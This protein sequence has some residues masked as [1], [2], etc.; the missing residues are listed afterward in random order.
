ML[1]TIDPFYPVDFFNE[2]KE[3]LKNNK[4]DFTTSISI[5]APYN[6][7]FDID[8]APIM[9]N[10]ESISKSNTR[11][12][13]NIV[14]PL[15]PN[16]EYIFQR[17]SAD[18]G[19]KALQKFIENE[20]LKEARLSEYSVF[21]SVK[22][23]DEALKLSEEFPGKIWYMGKYYDNKYRVCLCTSPIIRNLLRDDQVLLEKTTEHDEIGRFEADF[24]WRV[25]RNRDA[26]I[27]FTETPHIQGGRFNAVKIRGDLS[28]R[29]LI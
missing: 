29:F 13:V 8:S 19:K 4:V 27:K 28:S 11:W 17:R 22:N 1:V 21:F 20:P 2:C 26:L 14:N 24:N 9:V 7:Y 16:E 15:R 5:K 3:S 6:W 12:L 10:Y 18:V 25:L 23:R